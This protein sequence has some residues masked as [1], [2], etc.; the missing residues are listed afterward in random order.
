MVSDGFDGSGRPGPWSQAKNM[1]SDPHP[2]AGTHRAALSQLVDGELPA[3]ELSAVLA[4]F[5]QHGAARAD[6]HTYHLIGDALRSD[7]LAVAPAHD[8]RFLQALRLRLAQEPLPLDAPP[9]LAEVAPQPSAPAPDTEPAVP[10][11][12]RGA[13]WLVAPVAVAAGF[14][15]VA[16]VLLVNQSVVTPPVTAPTISQAPTAPTAPAV[17]V[18]DAQLDRYLAAH[19]HLGTGLAGA[20]NGQR[21]VQIVYEPK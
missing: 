18:R 6:W 16:A 3:G 7:E 8:E 13:N 17:L 2:S 14:V 15:A 9:R 19:R 21:S 20:G 11:R 4:D 12:R 10:G 5:R 1:Q